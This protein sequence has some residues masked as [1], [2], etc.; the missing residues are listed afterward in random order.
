MINNHANWYSELYT[1]LLRMRESY[2]ITINAGRDPV[3][4]A[5]YIAQF[6]IK[7]IK[8]I[9]KTCPNAVSIYFGCPYDVNH[10]LKNGLY[11]VKY[12]IHEADD[13]GNV[14][15]IFTLNCDN[16]EYKIKRFF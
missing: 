6:H 13:R 16:I 8:S 3:E 2:L 1:D 15:F 5:G 4:F 7:T 10:L 11:D 12:E 9:A 14:T